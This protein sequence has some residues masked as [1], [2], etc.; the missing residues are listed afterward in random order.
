MI[1]ILKAFQSL[2]S[3]NPFAFSAALHVCET[4]GLAT[5]AA[6][7]NGL[8]PKEKQAALVLYLCTQLAAHNGELLSELCSPSQLAS[9]AACFT[10]FPDSVLDSIEVALACQSAV[11]AGAPTDCNDI[12]VLREA[13]KCMKDLN[14]KQLRAIEIYLRC[15]LNEF[16]T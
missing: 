11:A 15:Q 14:Q 12:D 13:I 16:V 7:I 8:G 1:T 3:G 5:D 4:D 9:D 6:C 10:E 2:L